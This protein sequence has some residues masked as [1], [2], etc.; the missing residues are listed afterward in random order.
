MSD[1]L[2]PMCAKV[3]KEDDRRCPHCGAPLNR[4]RHWFESL[5]P[6]LLLIVGLVMLL[7]GGCTVVFGA[8]GLADPYSVGLAVW[9][10]AMG[11]VPALAG[12][13]LLKAAHKR[14]RK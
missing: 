4:A 3:V 6:T 14:W 5:S 11:I 12:I 9:F 10:I 8:I 7:P 1:Q 2:C 13:Y